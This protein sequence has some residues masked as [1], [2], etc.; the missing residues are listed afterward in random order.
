MSDRK[1]LPKWISFEPS[2]IIKFLIIF[3]IVGIIGFTIPFTNQIFKVLVPWALL[4][5]MAL[6]FYFHQEK[7]N[8]KT[9][10]IFSLVFLTGFLFEVIGVNTGIIFGYYRYGDSL[11]PKV[12]NTPILIGINWLMLSYLFASV[13]Q[14]LRIHVLFK[15]II[16]SFGLLVYDIILEQSAPMLDM[17]YW[18]NDTI[19]FRNYMAWFVVAIVL[20]MILNLGR[21]KLQNPITKT[22]LFSQIAFFLFLAVYNHLIS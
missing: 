14:L 7:Y 11:G 5:N 15:V 22:V 1:V 12:F 16:S 17:W 21:I 18:K 2:E 8:L 9:Y 20:Q 6:L 4:L 10:L 3:Y 19:P 13:I